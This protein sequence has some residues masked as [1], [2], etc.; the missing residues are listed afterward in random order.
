M[1]FACS[2]HPIQY[3]QLKHGRKLTQGERNDFRFRS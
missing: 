2:P 1:D 3:L